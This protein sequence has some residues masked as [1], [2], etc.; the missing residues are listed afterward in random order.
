MGAPI[1]NIIVFGVYIGVPLVRETT[2]L[3]PPACGTSH[4]I[5][6]QSNVWGLGFRVEG[7]GRRASGLG[8]KADV[9]RVKIRRNTTSL[10]C[11]F[12]SSA[13]V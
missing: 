4:F 5:L 9:L 2:I 1:M 8:C 13:S 6:Q 12:K 11:I 10:S 7:L 3:G